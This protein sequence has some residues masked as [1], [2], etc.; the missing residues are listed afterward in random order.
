MS[1][2][3]AM[4]RGIEM[5]VDEMRALHA[6]VSQMDIRR[7][8]MGRTVYKQAFW[9]GFHMRR[10]DFWW[11]LENVGMVDKRRAERGHPLRMCSRDVASYEGE[12]TPDSDND[13]GAI[14][15]DFESASR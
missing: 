2:T 12:S 15:D 11:N 8:S 13:P 6:T 7:T 9:R 4:T 10:C 14:C 3:A 1:C 5:Y